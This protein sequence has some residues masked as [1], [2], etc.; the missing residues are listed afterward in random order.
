MLRR[1]TCVRADYPNDG[2]AAALATV[3]LHH[4]V[5]LDLARVRERLART[6]TSLPGLLQAAEPLGFSGKCLRGESPEALARMPLPAIV[7][8]RDGAGPERYL[9]LHRVGPHTALLADPAEGVRKLSRDDFCRHWTGA[10]L[11]LVPERTKPATKKQAPA[12]PFNRFLGILRGHSR[13]LIEAF[14]CG[15]L[16][17]VLGISTSYFVQHLVDTVLVRGEGRL[18]NALALGMILITLFR[19][20]FGVLRHYL[21]AH[22]CRQVDLALLSDFTRH[23]VRLPLGY[24][25]MKRLGETFARIYDATTVREVI[26][27]TVLTA[28]VDGTLV[29]VLLAVLWFYDVPL[30]LVATAF[31]VLLVAAVAA[32]HPASGRRTRTMTEKWIALTSHVMED[33]NGVETV[34]ACGAERLRSEEGE[35][36]L[37]R[38]AQSTFS[39]HKLGIGAR[40]LSTFLTSAAGIVILWYGGHRVIH[41]ALTIGQLLFFFTLLGYLLA[42]LDRLASLNLKFQEAMGAVDRLYRILDVEA[43][44]LQDHR[45]LRFD[46]VR[47]A[48][49]L[50]DVGFRYG[51]GPDVLKKLNVHI[52]AGKTVAFVGVSGGGKSTLLRL[53]MGFYPPCEG[54]I[55]IDGVDLREFDLASLRRRVGL[56]AQEPFLFTGTVRENIALGLPE[57]TLAEVMA[58]ARAAGLNEFIA[59]LPDRYDTR[60]GERGANLSGGQRQRLA[61]ARALL[62]QPEVLIFDE[63]TSHLDTATEEAI[64]ENLKTVL[65]HKTAVLVAHRLSTVKD[66]DLIYVL[67]EGHIVE[68]GTHRQL[69]ALQGWYADLWRAQTGHKKGSWEAEAALACACQ[70][71]GRGHT[72]P[73]GLSH[74]DDTASTS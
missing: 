48:L 57:A 69:L 74:A 32:H 52:P 4:R 36:H 5:P 26:G 50:R 31:V 62:R 63:A 39:V 59:G 28:V 24:F 65:A 15:V 64:Q 7:T 35:S 21:T 70:V 30:A 23:V 53:L 72:L 11:V 22:L 17:M 41:G 29:L 68:Q 20:L 2:G 42:P 55:L 3:A 46:K 1:V 18:L 49:E 13:V 73:N 51:T 10:L 27:D 58:A 61:I 43:E 6:G 12:T 60:L 56:V 25:A 47:D 45:K 19:T 33:I 37:V 71:N 14:V 16:L 67:H 66:A 34:K 40:A 8:L 44:A 9:V 38:Y 54:R